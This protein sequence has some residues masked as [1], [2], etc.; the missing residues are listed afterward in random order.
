AFS[1]VSREYEASE[2]RE[3]FLSYEEPDTEAVAAFLRLRTPSHRTSGG[4]EDPVV[5]ELKV[6]GP[7]LPVG[8]A[9]AG[10][11][12][13][14]H[15]GFGSALLVEA[16]RIAREAGARRLFVLSAVGTREYYRRRGFVE[17]GAQMAKPLC[18]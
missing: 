13:Y 7:E 15:R 16:E 1:L 12:T 11:E 2:G 8:A 4:L 6:L 17:V 18:A 5:R 14:Q 3:T 9:P 10:S